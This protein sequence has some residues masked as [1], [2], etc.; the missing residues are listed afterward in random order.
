MVQVEN[1]MMTESTTAPVNGKSWTDVGWCWC[2][3]YIDHTIKGFVFL[4][5]CISGTP[6]LHFWNVYQQKDPTELLWS[7]KR[8]TT[9]ETKQRPWKPWFYLLKNMETNQKPWKNMKLPWKT[10]KPTKNHEKP[11]N[12]LEKPWKPTKNHE[13]PWN[14]FEKPWK[15]TK[16]HETG[17]TDLLDV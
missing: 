16:N 7:K 9:M 3:C 17:P 11:W 8:E 2:W 4:H 14:H 12:H 5:F 10:W 6:F 13:K 15:P 1:T